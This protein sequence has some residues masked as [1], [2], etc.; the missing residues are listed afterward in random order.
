MKLGGLEAGGTKMICA[1]GDE[2][3]NILEQQS[4]PTKSP[5]ETI[6]AIKSWFLERQPDALGVASF[7]PIDLDKTSPTYGHITT[8]PK[9]NWQN[10]PILQELQSALNVP[11]AFDFDVG[12]AAIAEWTAGAAKG[13]KSCLYI[14]VGTGIGGVLVAN[15][16]SVLVHGL[17]HCELGHMLMPISPNDPTPNGFC[18]YHKGCLEGLASG[19]SMGLR[20]NTNPSTLAPDHIAWEIESDYLA[21]M[22]H[23]VI[24]CLAPE[25]IVLGGG[26]MKNT[27]LYEKIQQKTLNLLGGYLA[28]PKIT[29]NI[30]TYI[31][32]PVFADSGTVGALMI[33]KK[34]YNETYKKARQ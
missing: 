12:A 34:I 22:C 32:P 27:F 33:A 25:K 20:W 21:A 7:G 28:H 15:G 11:T 19:K 6:P 14:T 8:T 4:F 24:V 17:Q 5:Q 30:G 26:V 31:V 23:N 10:Y 13:T 1:I 3:C 18:P 2:N 29:Q 9:P 16:E